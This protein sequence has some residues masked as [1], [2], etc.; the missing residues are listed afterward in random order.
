V[1]SFGPGSSA[2]SVGGY[3]PTRPIVMGSA[4]GA[5]DQSTSTAYHQF[6]A[7]DAAKAKKPVGMWVT[8]GVGVVILALIVWAATRIFGG[9][10]GGGQTDQP[11]PNPTVQTCPNPPASVE[12]A[13]HP[14]DGRVYGGQLS[15]PKLG[16]P[17]SDVRVG[18]DRIP[19]GRDTAEQ[20]IVI[21]ANYDGLSSWVAS[22]VVGELNAGDGF[23]APKQASEIVNRCIFGA[24]Y[25]D[26]AVQAET[27]KSEAYSV[28]GFDGWI[29]ETN[30]SF[31]I[32]NLATTSEKAIVIIVQTSAMSSSI[33]YASIP[34]DAEQ[35]LPDVEQAI[36]GLHVTR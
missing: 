25:G 28:D 13:D 23:Y 5:I 29:T 15:F 12:R 31:S 33:F 35:Y 7:M 26:T 9:T 17:W 20:D 27:L 18:E 22:V 16:Q 10:S 1:P 32:P 36:A 4:P 3:D 34:N 21:H 2:P 8:I 30:L 19:F 6:Q 14:S 24:F 11:I